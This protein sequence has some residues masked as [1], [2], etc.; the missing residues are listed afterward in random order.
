M[1]QYIQIRSIVVSVVFTFSTSPNA[2]AS[3]T[4][5]MFSV[6]RSHMANEFKNL[7]LFKPCYS[8]HS[9]S[10]VSVVLT[11]SASQSVSIPSPK[12][13]VRRLSEVKRWIA[14]VTVCLFGAPFQF[15]SG[16][17]LVHFECFTQR[18]YPLLAH[19]TICQVVALVNP[20]WSE[21]H[22][23][24]CCRTVVVFG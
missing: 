15:E 13:P 19:F 18:V 2:R 22:D 1:W 12:K 17:C 21:K 7:P 16:Q 3:S 11:L 10:V 4:L 9:C 5:M 20:T 8:P 24:W 23:S 6:Q 14:I